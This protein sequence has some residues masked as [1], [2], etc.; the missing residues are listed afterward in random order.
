M[1]AKIIEEIISRYNSGFGLKRSGEPFK[2]SQYLVK[3]ILKENNIQ[4]RNFAEAARVSDRDVIT[5][6][7]QYFKT[8]NP[9][10]AY[11]LGLLA[12]DGTIRKDSNS[13]KLTLAEKDSEILYKIKD[14]L[15][16]KGEVKHYQDSKGYE[17]ATLTFTSKEIKED[18][19]KYNIVP[20]KTFTFSFPKNLKKEYWKDFIRG[21]FDGDGSI[22]SAGKSA[23]RAQIC[24][25]QK[26]TLETIV[27]YLEEC[28]IQKPSIQIAQRVKPLY[29]F[30]Y[31]ST[32]TRQFFSVIYYENCLC[33]KRK[34]NKFIELI[35]RNLK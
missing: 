5:I 19:A 30:Q 13:I 14:E 25:A 9:N 3:K 15:S 29:Y 16:Y 7:H 31:S 23:I 1:D 6:N 28:G 10:M 33:L 11:I 20:S 21:Y 17:N 12:S 2:I 4:I 35:P 24:S 27:N 22:S 8:E 18:L 34:Y 32:R 26:E